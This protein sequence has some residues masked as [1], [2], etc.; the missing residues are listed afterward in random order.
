MCNAVTRGVGSE[1]EEECI[2][3]GKDKME[4]RVAVLLTSLSLCY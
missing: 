1:G 2:C 4:D 3:G